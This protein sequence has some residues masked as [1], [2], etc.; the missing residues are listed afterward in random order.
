MTSTNYHR[1]AV[2][3]AAVAASSEQ[4]INELIEQCGVDPFILEVAEDIGAVCTI[5]MIEVADEVQSA[6]AQMSDDTGPGYMA[7]QLA[8]MARAAVGV[9]FLRGVLVGLALRAQGPECRAEQHFDSIVSLP[10][11]VEFFRF[12]KVGETSLARINGPFSCRT[13]DGNIAHCDDGWLALDSQGHL[14]PV[15]MAVA[16][17]SYAI[18]GP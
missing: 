8:E 17:E 15:A 11:G 10:G 2:V 14:Y 1:E 13:I 9:S 6:A 5:A 3:T 4:P 16:S 18:V 12:Q 7:N